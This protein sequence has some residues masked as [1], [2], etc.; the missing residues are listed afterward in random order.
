[1]GEIMVVLLV[2]GFI[3]PIIVRLGKILREIFNG[4]K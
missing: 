3:V 4:R 1:M 2:V